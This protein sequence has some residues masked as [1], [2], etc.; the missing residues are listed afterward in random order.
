MNKIVSDFDAIER[1]TEK[2]TRV[3]IVGEIYVKYS[4][5]GNNRLE[6]F[7]R[8]Q[9]CEYMLPGLMG[10]ILFK[11][12]N[13]IEDIKLYGGNPFKKGVLYIP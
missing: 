12:D 4:P 10:F 3:G 8:T 9:D 1:S 6:E 7:L 11:I 2:K 13:R 5:L